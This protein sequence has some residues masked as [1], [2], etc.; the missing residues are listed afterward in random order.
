MASLHLLLF[1][2]PDAG[3]S[4]LLDAQQKVAGALPGDVQV[5]DCSGQSALELL[6][7][8][9]AFAGS[10]PLKKPILDADAVMLVIDVSAQKKQIND[11]FRQA[12]RWLKQLHQFRGKRTDVAALPVYVVLTKCDL[13]ATHDDTLVT[14]KTRIEVAKSEYEENFRKYLDQHAPGFGTIQL[15]VLAT[16]IKQPSFGDKSTKTAEPFGVSE[17]FRDC[18][19]SANDFQQRRQTSQSRLQ[20]VVVG[21]LGLVVMLA[22]SVVFL[23]E[24]QP[25]SRG[26]TLDE[27][28][29]L[30]LPKREATSVDRL[31]GTVQKLEDKKQ[32]L[33]EI[34]AHGD[35][36]R[37]P[38]ESQ[39]AVSRY[40]E[41]L[42][43]YLK[44]SQDSLAILKLPHFAKNDAEFKEL[45]KSVRAFTLPATY[46]KDWQE[47]RLT[48]RIRQ[49]RGE[50]DM[51]HAELKK[52]E[53][54]IRGQIDQNK[55]L[56]KAGNR[57]YGKLLDQDKDAPAEAKEWHQQY[58][59]QLT[60]RPA[61]PR[62]ENVPSVSRIFYEDLA[63]FEPVKTAQREWRTSKED[64][65][66]ISALIQ[67]KLNVG[68]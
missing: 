12:A 60:A 63:K 43:Q 34:E 23:S 2:P 64:L 35:F 27:K 16:S 33:T 54:W 21:M 41:E 66:N 11:D 18:L 10:H 42:S 67:K 46:A 31:A 1:G 4:A 57:L 52:E 37:L 38:T 3:K 62:D 9:K 20:N 6:Q 36:N 58:Q 48:K 44:L 55:T 40:R 56:L 30:A 24:F 17:L 53:A 8:E 39:E 50:Y 29:Q 25:P 28:L 22:L 61:T 14:W 59:A 65:T 68:S 15:K 49:V 47:T 26:T 7:S 51:L 13:L 45:E 19:R 5:I 32:K